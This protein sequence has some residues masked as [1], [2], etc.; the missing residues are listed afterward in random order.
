VSPPSLLGQARFALALA[1]WDAGRDRDRARALAIAARDHAGEQRA[2]V[3]AW[4]AK[5][6]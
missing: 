6:H 5:H 3:D 1:L 2:G 4:L